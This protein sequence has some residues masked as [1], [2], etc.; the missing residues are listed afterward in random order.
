M[1]KNRLKALEGASQGKAVVI[2]RLGVEAKQPNS[3]LRR[4]FRVE[5]IKN[6]KRVVAFVPGD[7]AMN[8][9]DE[10]DTV[11]IEGYHGADIPNV[12]YQIIKVGNTSL[13]RLLMDH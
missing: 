4:C 3:A 6:K 5:L 9:V 8:F 10:N 13:R 11:T 2:E 7:G 1:A 12:K